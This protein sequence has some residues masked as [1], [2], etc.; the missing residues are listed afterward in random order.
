MSFIL[1]ALKKSENDRQ[2][3][4]GPAL[5]EVRVPPPRS[6][7]PLLA[8]SIVSLLVVNLGVVAWLMLRKPA[9]A[10]VPETA[11]ASAAETPA[12]NSPTPPASTAQAPQPNANFPA[13]PGGQPPPQG[14]AQQ[15]YGQPGYPGQQPGGVPPQGSYGA[16][17]YP[18]NS[19]AYQQ[20]PNGGTNYAPPP[21]SGAYFQRNG[22]QG[23]NPNGYPQYPQGANAGNYPQAP[24]T[25]GGFANGSSGP[26][27]SE[28]A[29]EPLNPDDYA[30]AREGP[31]PGAGAGRVVRGTASG[32]PT[33]EEAASRT[34]I[35]P[36]HMDLHSYAPD[37]SKRF[38][39]VN[40][41]RLYEGQ[42]T[43]EGV[44]VESIT[45]DSAIMSYNGTRFVLDSE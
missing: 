10:A 1:D 11:A 32:L 6:K 17:G 2:R 23:A 31:A 19:T 38:V 44:K 14:Y 36:L 24:N 9:S 12:V 15:G 40:M 4:T 3:Q 13:Q 29:G 43:A 37:P 45:N 41:R 35:P 18:P 22:E 39:L 5:F 33:Y 26:V 42:S 16:N 30:P 27:L 28:S 20:A 8:I 21:N 34:Q 25:N 7:F